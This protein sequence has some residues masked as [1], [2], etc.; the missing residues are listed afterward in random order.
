MAKS[1]LS[2]GYCGN[3]VET[4]GLSD[5]SGTSG[6]MDTEM[7]VSGDDTRV[8]G[9]KCVSLNSGRRGAYGVPMQVVPLSKLSALQRKD[10]AN[11]FKSELERVRLFQK[12][13]EMQKR[14]GVAF[15]SASESNIGFNNGQNGLQIENSRKP[16]I[17]ASVPGNASKPIME[18]SRK[19]SKSGSVPGNK[20]KSLDKSN[21]ARGFNRG[22]SGKFET[23]ARSCLPG[24]VNALLMKDC[25][26]LLKKLMDHQYGYVFNTPVDVVKL[27]LPDYFTF[28]KHPMDLGTIKVKLGTRSYTSPL[29]FASDVRLTFSNALTYNP[30]NNDVHIMADT[31]SKFFATRWKSIEKK[32]PREDSPPLHM[33]TNTREDVKT[34]RP[35]P[36]SKKRKIASPPPQ[37]EIIPSLQPEIIPSPQPEIIPS[38]QPEVIAPAQPEVIA[39]AQPEVI[40]PTKRV[41]SIQEKQN[42]ASELESFEGEIPE[43][44]LDFLR[45]HSSNGKES[46]EGELEIDIDDLSDDTMFKL[47]KLLDDSLMEK[48]K[49]EAKVEACEIEVSLCY[50]TLP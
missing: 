12:K 23:S 2:G 5:G 47:R 28:I 45:Q 13:F 35:M 31:L 9:R 36:P 49:N 11:R 7:T 15:P 25:E 20:L 48:Q 38:P 14:N 41:M 24:T 10:L 3:A 43:H 16:S 6:R 30:P 33:K 46:E 39:P 44:I 34:A 50:L 18:T 29:E 8:S 17:S 32:L 27:N 19:L 26:L 37:P 42:I 40:T 4:G 1:R 21:K 22:S